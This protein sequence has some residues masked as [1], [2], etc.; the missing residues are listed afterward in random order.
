MGFKGRLIALILIVMIIAGIVSYFNINSM[1]Q[2]DVILM[3]ILFAIP[4]W[5]LGQQYDKATFLSFKLKQNRAMLQKNQKELYDILHH[6]DAYVWSWDMISHQIEILT[7]NGKRIEKIPKGFFDMFSL[8]GDS[9]HAHDRQIFE[10]FLQALSSGKSETEIF[11][12]LKKNGETKRVKVLGIPEVSEL[13]D[14][15]KINGIMIDVTEQ[16]NTE[17][18]LYTGKELFFTILQSIGDGVITTDSERKVTFMN[19]AAEAL[20]GWKFLESKGLQLQNVLYVINEQTRQQ[21]EDPVGRVMK[22]QRVVE[23]GEQILLIHKEGQ[24][25]HIDEHAAPIRDRKGNIGGTVIFFRNVSERKHHEE[26]IKHYAYY[27]MLT[28]LPNRR[29]FYRYLSSAV[30]KASET[31]TKIGVLFIDLDHFKLINDSLGHEMGDYVLTSMAKRL[32]QC[33]RP[34]DTVARLG[35][36]EFIVLHENSSEQEIAEMAETIKEQLSA[37][38]HINSQDIYVTASIGVSLYPDDADNADSLVRN[39]DL[40]MYT[41]KSSGKNGYRRYEQSL[42][43]R[44]IYEMEVDIELQNALEQDQFVLQYQPQVDLL[45]DRITGFEALIRWNH[46]KFG[47]VAP[48]DF[49]PIAEKTGLIV[50][51]GEWV[52]RKACEQ[53]KLWHDEGHL[54][55]V[56]VNISIHQLYDRQFVAKVKQI[57][58]NIQLDPKYVELEITENVM[59]DGS[60][61]QTLQQLKEIGIQISIDDFGIGYSSLSYLKRLPI[62]AVKIDKSFTQGIPSDSADSAIIKTMIVLAK[63]LGL[64]VIAEGVETVE[65]LEFLKFNNCEGGQGFLFSKPVSTEEFIKVFKKQNAGIRS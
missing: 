32:Q 28:N 50:P 65:Q 55:K 13:S 25:I 15:K 54:V 52:L 33:I 61:I 49:I 51:I 34:E 18:E 6:V 29:H 23:L 42:T 30:E 35:G 27:D 38:L 8:F 16:K 7:P 5:F 46:P 4:A 48:S 11:R 45:Q 1:L 3:V 43:N 57:L 60:T 63:S 37:P 56:A 36:D 19:P 26:Q 24:E 44:V 10:N 53:C 31:S 12:V 17:E 59:E 40:T 2:P 58:E 20:T 47:T 39:A 64:K 14:L 62:D 21:V 9:I 22:E 41:V